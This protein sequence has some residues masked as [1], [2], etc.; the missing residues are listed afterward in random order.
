MEPLPLIALVITAVCR[1]VGAV[2]KLV[3]PDLTE[4][5]GA[6][7]RLVMAWRCSRTG[8]G[9]AILVIPTFVLAG[10]SRAIFDK[11]APSVSSIIWNAVFAVGCLW[12]ALLVISIVAFYLVRASRRELWM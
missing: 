1:P 2:G 4:A 11:V 9:A 12:I 8:A 3:I 6:N 5:E 10:I 7:H